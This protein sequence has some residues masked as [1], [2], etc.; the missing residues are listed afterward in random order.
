MDLAPNGTLLADETLLSMDLAPNEFLLPLDFSP[1]ETLISMTLASTETPVSLALSPNET[2]LSMV[3]A[4]N[5]TLLAPSRGVVLLE[6]HGPLP[7]QVRR[8]VAEPELDVARRPGPAVE[9]A[10]G[11]LRRHR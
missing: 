10:Q 11:A 9:G 6:E 7:L 8:A 3:L 1:H 5:E 2:L 4:P